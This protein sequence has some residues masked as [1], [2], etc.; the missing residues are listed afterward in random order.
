MLSKRELEFTSSVV[1]DCWLSFW[2][3]SKLS[4]VGVFVQ[5]FNLKGSLCGKKHCSAIAGTSRKVILEKEYGPKPFLSQ[6]QTFLCDHFS[7][8]KAVFHSSPG[9]SLQWPSH[10]P[11]AQGDLKKKFYLFNVFLF[12]IVRMV[13]FSSLSTVS[14]SSVSIFKTI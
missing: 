3:L 2:K 1:L 11:S 8:I 7:P 13:S 9:L 6:K 4:I 12:F 14:F 10:F 5:F